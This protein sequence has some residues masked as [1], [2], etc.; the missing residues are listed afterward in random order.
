MITVKINAYAPINMRRLAYNVRHIRAHLR[1][2]MR[3]FNR[4]TGMGE[5]ALI[6]LESGKSAQCWLSTV[7]K[8]LHLFNQVLIPEQEMDL[9]DLIYHRF[10]AN[11]VKNLR[12]RTK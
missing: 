9:L 7:D 12:K 3:D 1:I 2:S 11:D 8:V 10:D 5:P 4:Y 6:R